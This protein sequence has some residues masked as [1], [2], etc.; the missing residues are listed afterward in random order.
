MIQPLLRRIFGCS[1]L[2][3]FDYGKGGMGWRDLWQDS[4]SLI[5]NDPGK[6]RPLL[7]N[8]FSGVRIDGSN[9]TII[10]KKTGE[11]IADRN[12]ISRVWMDHGVWPLITLDLYINETG[13]LNILFEQAGYFRDHQIF[14]SRELTM[15]GTLLQEI[16]SRIK[17]EAFIKV[18]S[19][20]M[21]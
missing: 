8:N 17:Q 5:L 2:P 21:F 15:P 6:V 9:A 11:F 1:F 20:N 7:I 16:I 4:L 10:G 18:H 14:R 13:D 3:D 19:L 12:R